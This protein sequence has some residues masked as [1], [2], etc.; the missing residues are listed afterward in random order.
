[1]LKLP[2]SKKFREYNNERII[3]INVHTGPLAETLQSRQPR[4]NNFLFRR[5]ITAAVKRLKLPRRRKLEFLGTKVEAA[6][7]ERHETGRGEETS[8]VT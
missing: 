3:G 2:I 1:M 6:L 4:K 7:L 8:S 5:Q